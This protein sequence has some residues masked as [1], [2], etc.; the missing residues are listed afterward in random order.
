MGIAWTSYGLRKAFQAH[1]P[2]SFL[3]PPAHSAL[4]TLHSS[5]IWTLPRPTKS[6]LNK[7]GKDAADVLLYLANLA[8]C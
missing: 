3:T 1:S 5:T 6:W 8:G 7:Y 4:R 2:P